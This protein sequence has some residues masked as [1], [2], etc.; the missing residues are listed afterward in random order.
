[1]KAAIA[2]LGLPNDWYPRPDG[3]VERTV[4]ARPGLYGGVGSGLLP[5]AR[6]PASWRTV[7]K[8]VAGT[9][10]TTDDAAFFGA[11]CVNAN[12][13]RP[14]WQADL[15]RWAQAGKN[16]RLGMPICGVNL[17]PAPVQTAQPATPPRG[18]GK[19]GR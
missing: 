11:G 16:Y 3:I 14:E 19:H 4:C 13:E 8:Y 17:R 15:L 5:S 6:C 2:Q 7:E 10:P 1:M 9:E 12:A 18:K